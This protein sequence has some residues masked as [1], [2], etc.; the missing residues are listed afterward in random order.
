M[1]ATPGK[2]GW[3]E[4]LPA[5][6]YATYLL[7]LAG[8]Y[9]V[10]NAVDLYKYYIAGVFFPGLLLLPRLWP[11]AA[12]S[13]LLQC[14]AAYLLYMLLSSLWSEQVDAAAL[15]RDTRYV[16]YILLFVLLSA[17]FA[18]GDRRLRALGLPV[19]TA[20]AGCAALA[21]IVLFEPALRWPEPGDARLSGIGIT[22]NPNPSA[23]VYGFFGV[24]ALSL[25]RRGP[26]WRPAWAAAFGVLLLYVLLTRSDGGLLALAT[27]CAT[28]LLVDGRLRGAHLAAGGALLLCAAAYLAWALGLLHAGMDLGFASRLPIWRHVLDSWQAAPLFG[29]GLQKVLV[30]GAGGQESTVNYAH[31]LFLS[32]LRDGGLLGL[33]LLLPVYALAL[34]RGL[35]RALSGNDALPLALFTFGMVCV[36]AD[37]D[38]AVTRPRELWIILWLPLGLLVAADAAAR[39]QSPKKIRR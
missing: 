26:G 25:A 34:R 5:L 16:A 20:V 24:C 9:F 28:L 27:A 1:N 19:V 15:W 14:A 17:L 37:V 4:R 12:R 38:Q 6:V 11:L 30:V 33:G 22:E 29:N 18:D 7:F 39:A 36:L 23:F 31:S 21:A 8:F 10:P 13:R 3:R 2:R 32:T 35:Q